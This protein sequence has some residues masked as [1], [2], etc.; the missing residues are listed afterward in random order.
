VDEQFGTHRVSRRVGELVSK[1]AGGLRSRWSTLRLNDLDL[2]P[3]ARYGSVA[4][5][6]GYLLL[7]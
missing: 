4:D 5:V 2:N 1:R 7:W 6:T 3:P